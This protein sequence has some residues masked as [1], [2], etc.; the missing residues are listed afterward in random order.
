MATDEMMVAAAQAAAQA[1]QQT[2]LSPKVRNPK[3]DQYPKHLPHD[4]LVQRGYIRLLAE[5]FGGT[6]SEV[7][8][9]EDADRARIALQRIGV[10]LDFQFNPNQL[11]RSVTARTDTQLWINQSPSQILQPGIGDMAFGWQM[12]FNRE[13]EVAKRTKERWQRSAEE[14]EQDNNELD[15]LGD[16]SDPRVAQRLG[17][18]ADIMIL[19]Q[20]TGQKLTQG[21]I[22]F[23]V[24]YA[25]AR[26]GL[27]TEGGTGMIDPNATVLNTDQSDDLLNANITNSA[28]MV[29]NPVRVVFSENFMVDGYVNQI[30]V[31][32]QKFS[33]E[34]I[35][36]VAFVDISMHAL[37]QGFARK[38]TVF[39]QLSNMISSSHS[40]NTPYEEEDA[41]R[42]AENLNDDSYTLQRLG[43]IGQPRLLAGF[44]HSPKDTGGFFPWTGD[45]QTHL[46]DHQPVPLRQETP[47]NPTA[48]KGGGSRVVHIGSDANAT[49]ISYAAVGTM[50]TG[51]GTLGQYL[52]DNADEGY[53]ERILPRVSGS[54]DVGM[55]IRARLKAPDLASLLVLWQDG[56]G[57]GFDTYKKDDHFF[58][59]WPKG[60]RKELFA[61]G[62]DNYR[63]PPK[64]IR[65]FLE[66]L[67]ETKAQTKGFYTRSF[68]IMERDPGVYGDNFYMHHASFGSSDMQWDF[69]DPTVFSDH[70][71]LNFPPT[72]IPA[73]ELEY[74]LAKGFYSGTGQGADDLYPLTL[75]LQH[76]TDSP[77]QDVVFEVEYQWAMTC[78]NR[79]YMADLDNA[80]GA[81]FVIS[82]TGVLWIN[83]RSQTTDILDD[84]GSVGNRQKVRLAGRLQGIKGEDIEDTMVDDNAPYWLSKDGT[85]HGH[86]SEMKDIS[87][88]FDSQYIVGQPEGT[89]NTYLYAEAKPPPAHNR[90]LGGVSITS[91][92]TQINRYGNQY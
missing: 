4:S 16:P 77:A 69:V 82:D 1:A 25:E 92:D 68:P 84:A 38:T 13:A 50:Q 72:W 29:P 71:W 55:A 61:I 89:D 48:G 64:A 51:D 22:D 80:G 21:V 9:T 79:F 47:T 18:L 65:T 6:I 53:W 70:A 74:N 66:L 87:L 34:M 20:I 8:G 37:Y 45:A 27:D 23:S 63:R 43:F 3:F 90:L 75:T 31:S 88:F 35:P 56:G 49:A 60:Q 86:Q 42:V 7:T 39:T 83:P 2:Y 28:F 17:V 54:S 33:P 36:T 73:S 52:R 41:N 12:L 78:R 59:E 85:Q 11:T 14:L 46:K 40:G 5:N 58:G 57:G 10:R 76:A 67:N 81:P 32:I 62:V 91:V 44:D 15:N 19:D 24:A 30:T 26:F